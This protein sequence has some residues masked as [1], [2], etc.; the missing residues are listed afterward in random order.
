[1]EINLNPYVTYRFSSRGFSPST[2]AAIVS[3][4]QQP[5]SALELGQ[6]DALPLPS[7]LKVY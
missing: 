1:M 3:S 5:V 2:C 7:A 6:V 4:G